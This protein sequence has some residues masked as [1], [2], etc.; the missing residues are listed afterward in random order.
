[1]AISSKDSIIRSAESSE[2]QL[3]PASK[4]PLRY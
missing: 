3:R 2:M 4:L 1:V